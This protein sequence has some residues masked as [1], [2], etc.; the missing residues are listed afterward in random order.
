MTFD[1]LHDEKENGIQRLHIEREGTI[2][3]YLFRFDDGELLYQGPL[4][5]GDALTWE[6]VPDDA[7]QFAEN[8][9]EADLVGD[10]DDWE[11]I[12]E[13]MEI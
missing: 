6:D 8:H 7:R 2:E 3:Q 5:N 11:D 1:I 13:S 12:R 10:T 4:N 9:F